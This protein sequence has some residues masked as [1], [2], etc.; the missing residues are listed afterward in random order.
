MTSDYLPLL[1][2][3]ITSSKLTTPIT[4]ATIAPTTTAEVPIWRPR[5]CQMI[6][7]SVTKKNS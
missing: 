3:V 5:G 1:V 7:R 2:T 6:K 4:R